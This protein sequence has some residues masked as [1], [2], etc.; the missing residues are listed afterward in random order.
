MAFVACEPNQTVGA[1][2][3][4]AMPVILARDDLDRWLRDPH[5]TACSLARPYG[6]VYMR[7]IS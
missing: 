3:P 2:H 4:K 7:V 1:V 6:D 5:E